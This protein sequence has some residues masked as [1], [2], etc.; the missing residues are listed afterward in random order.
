LQYYRNI[1]RRIKASAVGARFAPLTADANRRNATPGPL[2]PE[3]CIDHGLEFFRS[4]VLATLNVCSDALINI[5][6][7]IEETATDVHATG[8]EPELEISELAMF[9]AIV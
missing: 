5:P 6:Q 1:E 9:D 3:V 4:L 7:E 2:S 8:V